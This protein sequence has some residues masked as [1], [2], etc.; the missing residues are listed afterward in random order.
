MHV[1]RFNFC[2]ACYARP[3]SKNIQEH[4]H[5]SITDLN[6]GAERSRA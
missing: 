1:Y 6:Y 5:Q 2:T 3:Q 4:N